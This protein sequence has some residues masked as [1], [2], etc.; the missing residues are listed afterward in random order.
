MSANARELVLFRGLQEAYRVHFAT[1]G[2][3]WVITGF[4]PTS[5]TLE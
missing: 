5:R 2:D 3:D 1:R 4:E